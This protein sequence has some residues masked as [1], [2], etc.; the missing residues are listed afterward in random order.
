MKKLIILSMTLFGL[1]ACKK[2]PNYYCV[3]KENIDFSEVNYSGYD[4]KT[5]FRWLIFKDKTHFNIWLD[6][7]NVVTQNKLLYTGFTLFFDEEG[8]KQKKVGVNFPIKT[9]K[10]FTMKDFKSHF[11]NDHFSIN[12][13]NELAKIINQLP[14]EG[15]Y[16]NNGEKEEFNYLFDK[17]GYEIELA[18]KNESLTY[19][20]RIPLSKIIVNPETKSFTL[21][22]E[23]GVLDFELPDGM[24]APNQNTAIPNTSG[25]PGN[26]GGNSP[27]VM[28]GGVAGKQRNLATFN[29]IEEPIR[30]WFKVNL[31]DI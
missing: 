21:G 4:A 19:R 14:K 12:T 23:S 11:N 22:I 31:T 24:Q 10:T 20:L 7:D 17:K 26:R 29:Q 27:G 5:G 25:I 30:L 9:E 8:K 16:L 6:T 13:T 15:F 18:D 28:G 3:N 2:L 1:L